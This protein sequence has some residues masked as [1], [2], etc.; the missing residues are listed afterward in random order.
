M[1]V[2]SAELV[3]YGGLFLSVAAGALVPVIPTGALVG[4]AAALAVADRSLTGL[5]LV[6]V[7]GAAGALLG[8][9]AL[10]ALLRRGSEPIRRWYARK[11]PAEKQRSEEL[12]L[13][14]RPV[15]ALILSRLV[16]GGRIPVMLAAVMTRQSWRWFLAGDVI[17]VLAWAGL[18]AA[19]GTVGGTIFDEEWQAVALA[20]VLVL[21]IGVGPDLVKR[22][23]AARGRAR[24]RVGHEPSSP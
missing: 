18:Y 19:I 1:A 4:A 17:A 6:L 12:R 3:T 5:L 15:F 14:E 8:D 20:V 24:G 23:S 21:V 10:L 2:T 22:A 9:A 11:V 13:R 16:P 7:A